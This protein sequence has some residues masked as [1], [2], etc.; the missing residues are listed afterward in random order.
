MFS[1]NVASSNAPAYDGSEQKI[2]LGDNNTT[3]ITPAWFAALAFIP[4]LV[5]L[6]VNLAFLYVYHSA[7][8]LVWLLII[9]GLLASLASL[10]LGAT[11]NF[12][13]SSRL[14][15]FLSAG[16]FLAILTGTLIGYEVYRHYLTHYWFTHEA[17]SYS[18]VLSTE[19]AAAYASAGKLL[20]DVDARIDLARTVGYRNGST[21]CA[22]PISDTMHLQEEAVSAELGFWAVGIDCCGA[23][24]EFA[25]DDA[26]NPRARGGVVIND[27]SSVTT[28]AREHFMRALH[29]AEA[30][31][32]IHA[33]AQPV[34]VRWVVDPDTVELNVFRSGAGYIFA[35]SAAYLL[36]CLLV[37]FCIFSASQSRKATP[38]GDPQYVPSY[39]GAA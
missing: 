4:F 23:R 5:F 21:Y 14:V 8:P 9:T 38:P 28:T 11:Q 39:Y 34:F 31:Y 1:G 33:A 37:T 25:C 17:D 30:V 26:L 12:G 2:L 15:L 7:A 19:P 3:R 29:Q 24:G 10:L 16:C 27:E 22:A 6:F 13:T 35:A 32:Q 36:L 20:F 18:D